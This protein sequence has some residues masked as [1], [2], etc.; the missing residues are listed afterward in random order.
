MISSFSSLKDDTPARSSSPSPFHP[1]AGKKEDKSRSHSPTDSSGPTTPTGSEPHEPRF[2]Q[3]VDTIKRSHLDAARATLKEG[4]LRDELEEEIERDCEVLRSFLNAA[5]II[6]EISPRSQDSIIGTGER[7]ACKIVAAALRDRG[8]DS[9]LVVLDNIVD[10]AMTA[11]TDAAITATGDQGVAQLGQSFYDEL[12]VRLGERLKECGPRIPVITG[13]FGAV[14]GSLLAQI[15]R[16]YTDLCAA[17]CAVGVAASELQV[18]K[19]VDGIF[20]ADPRKVPS[21]RLVPSITPDEAAE[22]TYYGSEVIHPFT[23]E[24]VIRAKIPIR[25]KNVDNP[26][27]PGT[28][29]LPDQDFPLPNGLQDRMPTAV[30]IKD[31]IIVLNIHSNR[32]TISHG[33]LARIFGTLDRAGVVVDLISTSE[34]HVSMAMQHFL[35]PRRLERLIRDLEKIGDITVSYDMAILSLVGRN[36]RNAI[37]SAGLMFASLAK[38]EVNI[39]MISQG[40]SE[41]N[42]SCV[43]EN[44]DAIKALNIIHDS[45]LAIPAAPEANGNANG[46][47]NGYVHTKALTVDTVNPAVLNVEADL[48]ATKLAEGEKLPFGEITYA[49]IGNPQEKVL[50]QKPLTYWRQ[51]ASLVEYPDLLKHPLVNELFPAD[52]I[53]K[54]TQLHDEFGSIG[55]YTGSKGSLPIRQRVAQFIEARDGFPA[56]PEHIYLTGGATPGVW[57]ILGLALRPGDGALIPRPQ[58]PVYTACLAHLHA[59]P[60]SYSLNETEGWALDLTSLKKA[61]ARG[62]NDLSI[63]T[64]KALVV[65][66]PGNPTGSCLSEEN[67]RE[68]VQI[69]Y[70][71][72]LLLLADE[73]YQTNVYEPERKPFVSFKQVLRSM[74]EPI[75]SSVELVSFHSISKGVSGECGRRGGYIETVNLDPGVEEL[76]LK[77]ASISLCAPVSGQ[78]GV[79]LLVSPPKPGSPSYELFKEESRVIHEGMRDRSTFMCKQF[80]ALEGV[81]CQPAEGAMYLFPQLTLPPRAI[82][83]AKKA[84]K[85]AD[86]FY[87]LALLDATGICTV[88]GSGFGQEDGTYHLRVTTLAPGVED[89]M[90]RITQF[91]EQFLSQY[92]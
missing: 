41:I 44:K 22:L 52:A 43:I 45:C 23:M 61:I 64:L 48:L 36:M 83:A 27:G 71:E 63:K 8:V 92:A 12:A 89:M 50:K 91:H 55:A 86:V 84:G 1:I 49:N 88:A 17:L 77:M 11:A 79:D 7:L 25:I 4:A 62:R 69:A 10:A 19:E 47:S 67:M 15:G 68:I 40:A 39:E 24:Q 37:G 20:T 26:G 29:I 82:E 65:I 81:S 2:H 42:I 76:L 33:F 75:A 9:E 30:T 57:M 59:V 18:W 78:I 32:K 14:P 38:A 70:D 6:D 21:A 80:N 66:N 56:D 51:V 72:S 85:E 31:Q 16:G 28:I 58:Y 73:V 54:A 5:H 87:A 90:A 13:Y 46:G 35:N 34:V 53:A 60:V 3:T 74:P